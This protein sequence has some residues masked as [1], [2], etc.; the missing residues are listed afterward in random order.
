MADELLR[1]QIGT[2]DLRPGDWVVNFGAREYARQT[3]RLFP[4]FVTVVWPAMH[5]EDQRMGYQTQ[6]HAQIARRGSLPRVCRGCEFTH[7]QV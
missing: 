5:L 4:D 3:R 2:L 7:D 1:E 6:M